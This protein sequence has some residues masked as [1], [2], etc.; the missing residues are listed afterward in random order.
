M[1]DEDP[2]I[3]DRVP[4]QHIAAASQRLPPATSTGPERL[5]VTLEA[6]WA[7]LVTISFQ[8]QRMRHGRSTHWAWVAY[9]AVPAAG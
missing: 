1:T 4:G 7:G 3:L 9:R 2:G 8:R 5:D 6:G